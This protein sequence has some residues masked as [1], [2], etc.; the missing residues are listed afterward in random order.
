MATPHILLTI[1]TPLLATSSRDTLVLSRKVNGVFA[2]ALAVGSPNPRDEHDTNPLY[3]QNIFSWDNNNNNNSENNKTF[4]VAVSRSSSSSSSSSS[5]GG[6]GAGALTASIT[7]AV[8]IGHGETARFSRN[9]LVLT[10]PGKDDDDGVGGG[11]GGNIEGAVQPRDRPDLL[12]KD[13]AATGSCCCVFSV[14]DVP[15]TCRVEVMQSVGAP[16]SGRACRIFQ[17]EE[18]GLSRSVEIRVSNTVSFLMPV[19]F[20][21]ICLINNPSFCSTGRSDR[22]LWA[23][24]L[25]SRNRRGFRW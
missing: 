16:G 7:N 9:L 24:G 21:W 8:E 5:H 14:T 18:G 3:S 13:D 25:W 15:P 2:T 4:R 17:S 6:S 11:G 19:L 1:D 20:S 10:Q 22:W 23:G 12:M